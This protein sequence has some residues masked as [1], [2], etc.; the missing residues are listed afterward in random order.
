MLFNSSEL[1]QQLKRVPLFAPLGLESL[2]RAL[3][4]GDGVLQ[5]PFDAGEVIYKSGDFG[6]T[7]FIVLEGR[8]SLR[9]LRRGDIQGTQVRQVPSGELFGEEPLISAGRRFLSAVAETPVTVLELSRVPVKRLF[10][11]DNLKPHFEQEVERM[12]RTA[13]SERLGRTGIFKRLSQLDLESLAQQVRVRNLL[14]GSTVY[15]E[16]D[17]ATHFYGVA[18]GTVTLGRQVG[19]MQHIRAWLT[20]GDFFGDLELLAPSERTVTATA[21]SALELFEIPAQVLLELRL[22]YPTLGDDLRRITAEKHVLVKDMQGKGLGDPLADMIRMGDRMGVAQSMLLI[23]LNTCIRCGNCAWSCEQTHGRSRLVRRGETLQHKT[24]GS[25]ALT[26]SLLPGSCQH[27]TDAACMSGCPTGAIARELD[28]EVFVREESCIGCGDCSKRCP[29]GNITIAPVPAEEALTLPG[30]DLQKA[31]AVKCDNCRHYAVS[32]CVHNCPTG[33]MRRV[34]PAE[35]FPEMAALAGAK[36]PVAQRRGL[37]EW[38][39]LALLLGVSLG[40]PLGAVGYGM[41]APTSLRGGSSLGLLCGVGALVM[42]GLTMAYSARKRLIQWV[43]RL[44]PRKAESTSGMA[45]VERPVTIDLRHWLPGH[46][47]LALGA[48][49]LAGVHAGG[50]AS[51][52]QGLL[53]QT[54]FVGVMGTGVVGV[55]LYRFVPPLLT[56]LEDSPALLEDLEEQ[57]AALTQALE[58]IVAEQ[59]TVLRPLLVQLEQA[60]NPTR[61]VWKIVAL[62]LSR[63]RFIRMLQDSQAD[64][65]RQ[66]PFEQRTAAGSMLELLAHRRHLEIQRWLQLVMRRWLP[67][68]I[69]VAVALCA[70]LALHLI[71][72]A[73]Y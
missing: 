70:M 68:H 52:P 27:C 22:K 21:Q 23:D 65:L 18:E 56:R 45:K 72:V 34:N 4:T 10:S 54:L 71:Q 12:Q 33:A 44:N 57:E 46:M 60:I 11:K 35:Y 61:W 62:R 49:I 66:L 32:A 51:S 5:R 31:K 36:A 15:K 20:E 42:M 26:M 9:F 43:M 8:V 39:E 59:N 47:L 17:P 69:L 40:V 55:A 48:C 25:D 19:G 64:L 7:V 1:S 38:L 41:S 24:P 37:R 29:W 3:N 53:L 6:S 50:T 58:E 73:V 28:G 13:L 14:R 63:A 67:P 2:H 16:G 30:G